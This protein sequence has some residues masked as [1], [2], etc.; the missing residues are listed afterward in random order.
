VP[1]RKA[2][3]AAQALFRPRHNQAGFVDFA[4]R[5][6]RQ[7]GGIIIVKNERG[8]ILRIARI[9]GPNISRAQIT[10]WIISQRSLGGPF[11]HFSKP[12]TLGALRGDKNPPA[13]QRVEAAVWKPG[14]FPG[15]RYE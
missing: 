14:E 2:E 13:G 7:Q 10:G 1:W 8:Q 4:R 11:C 5:S 3:D 12:W 6:V 15:A 9:S